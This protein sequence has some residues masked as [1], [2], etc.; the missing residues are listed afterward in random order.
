MTYHARDKTVTKRIG[1]AFL[2]YCRLCLAS[3]LMSV[4][5]LAGLIIILGKHRD[6]WVGV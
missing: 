1:L 6:C 2:R 5:H 4:M 3:R